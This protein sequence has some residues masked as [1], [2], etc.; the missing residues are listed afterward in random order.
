MVDTIV[1]S[2][3]KTLDMTSA[4]WPAQS[5]SRAQDIKL[6]RPNAV[7]VSIICPFVWTLQVS[8]RAGRES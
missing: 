8:E 5:H 7:R 3:S 2:A 1:A 4:V 6:V